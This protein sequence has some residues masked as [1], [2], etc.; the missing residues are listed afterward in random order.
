M[1]INIHDI[2]IDRSPRDQAIHLEKIR[3]ELDKAGYTVV[4]TEWLDRLNAAIL[5]RGI[6]A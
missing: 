4:K 6:E 1:T 2:I 3:A 5:K